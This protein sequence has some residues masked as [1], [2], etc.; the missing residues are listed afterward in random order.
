MLQEGVFENCIFWARPLRK[1]GPDRERAFQAWGK[2]RQNQEPRGWPKKKKEVGLA[3]VEVH[4]E[5]K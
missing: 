5:K 2:P 3:I 4:G 1:Q